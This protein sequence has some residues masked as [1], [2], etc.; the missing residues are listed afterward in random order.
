MIVRVELTKEVS[1]GFKQLGSWECLQIVQCKGMSPFVWET[2]KNDS[3]KY[4]D[5]M[6]C[7]LLHPFP[8]LNNEHKTSLE[9]LWKQTI[10]VFLK[11]F[12]A[13]CRPGVWFK[14]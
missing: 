6:E 8:P 10:P 2:C 5:T 9:E 11:N 4:S 12:K 3:K 7:K 13:W 1:K 14:A